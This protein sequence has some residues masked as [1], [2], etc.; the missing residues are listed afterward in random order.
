MP[1]RFVGLRKDPN[2]AD[3]EEQDGCIRGHPVLWLRRLED[4]RSPA[5]R[6]KAICMQGSSAAR[7]LWE[8][9]QRV[10]WARRKFVDRQ[11]LRGFTLASVLILVT[12][13]IATVL[14]G[15]TASGK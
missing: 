1:G 13:T 2:W 9:Q 10:D 3:I 6:G 7:L 5:T 4:G 11:W 12:I 15:W 14:A 8:E